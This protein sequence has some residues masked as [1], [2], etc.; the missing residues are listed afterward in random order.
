MKKVVYFGNKTSGF[1]G[2]KTTLE[3]L[4]PLL[5]EIVDIKSYSHKKNKLFRLLHM[6]MGFLRNVNTADYIIIDV[7]SSTALRYAEIIGY[8]SRVFNKNYILVL[9]G[10]NLPKVYD[11]LEQRI[12]RLFDGA[13]HIIAPSHYLQSFFESKGFTVQLIPN[14]I[15]LEQYPYLKRTKIRPKILALRGFKPV[16]NPMMTVKAIKTLKEQGISPELRLLANSDEEHYNEVLNYIKDN[17]L[18]DCITVLPKQK[19]TVWIEESKNFDIMVSNP[20]I[21]N[22]PI[23]ILEGMALGMCVITTN[24][25]GVPYLVKDEE[26]VLYVESDDSKGLADKI[27]ELLTDNNMAIKLSTNARRKAEQFDWIS[28]KTLWEKLLS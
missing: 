22:T 2:T 4:E 21:D 8:L 17:K 13:R 20:I 1:Q 7:Y 26:E 25:G 24:V 3:T 23:S 27:S 18:Q 10:G 11:K 28:V 16:Y 9:H 6:I 14:V 12:N 5:S 15:E 19:K